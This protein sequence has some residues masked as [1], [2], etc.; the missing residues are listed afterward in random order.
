MSQP[1][2]PDNCTLIDATAHQARPRMAVAIEGDRIQAVCPAS[3]LRP[4]PYHHRI[5]LNGA[6][7]L[8]GLWDVHCHLGV[9]YPAPEGVSL[10]GTEAERTLRTLRHA[11]DALR[12]GV[13]ALRVVGE[14]CC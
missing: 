14:A 1:L 3:G 10:F 5:D 11:A 8:P 7:L 6:V 2:L 12:A 9:Y 4:K 13:T